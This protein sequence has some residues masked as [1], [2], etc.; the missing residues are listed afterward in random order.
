MRG[1]FSGD[2]HANNVISLVPSRPEFSGSGVGRNL[3]TWSTVG[4]TFNSFQSPYG[5]GHTLYVDG[6]GDYALHAVDARTAFGTGDFTVEAWVYPTQPPPG[7]GATYDAGVFGHFGTPP[8]FFFLTNN[9]Y[10]PAVWDGT[11]QRTGSISVQP[12]CWSH[13]SWSRRNGTLFMHVNGQL[14]YQAAYTSNFTSTSACYSGGHFGTNDRYYK[15]Y[16]AVRVTRGVGRY[17]GGGYVPPQYLQQTGVAIPSRRVSFAVEPT[18]TVTRRGPPIGDPHFNNVVLLLPFEHHLNDVS[19]YRRGYA[20]VGS[21]FQLATWG[22]M[23]RQQYVR[24]SAFLGGSDSLTYL[25]FSDSA[26]LEFGASDFCM[27]AWVRFGSPMEDSV[28]WGK[29]NAFDYGPYTL[30]F[31]AS[32]GKLRFASSATGTAWE[33]QMFSVTSLVAQRWYH[34]AITRRGSAWRMFIDGKLDVDATSSHSVQDTTHALRFGS[35]SD[36]VG[37]MY[38]YLSHVRFTKGVA[39]YTSNFT[40]PAL[41][42]PSRGSAPRA[43]SLTAGLRP[44]LRR[45]GHND[46]RGYSILE[47]PYVDSAD[48]MSRYRTAAAVASGSPTITAAGPL[49]FAK[50]LSLNGSSSYSYG[51]DSRWALGGRPF[52]IQGWV[53]LTSMPSVYATVMSTIDDATQTGWRLIIAPDGSVALSTYDS[54]NITIALAG[55]V[56]TNRWVH[57][58]V[59]WRNYVWKSFV[60][61]ARAREGTR[62]NTLDSGPQALRVGQTL[63]GAWGL[64][65]YLRGLRVDVDDTTLRYDA[66]RDV[67]LMRSRFLPHAGTL[68]STLEALTGTIG[69]TTAATVSDISAFVYA[70]NTIAGSMHPAVAGAV[71]DFTN[72]VISYGTIGALSGPAISALAAVLNTVGSVAA[73][74]SGTTA[75]FTGQ[76]YDILLGV[77]SQITLS[78]PA[79]ALALSELVSSLALSLPDSDLGGYPPIV[80]SDHILH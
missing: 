69:S 45:G 54:P 55:S 70:A 28:L 61:G 64:T 22:V 66:P 48:D 79:A 9:T 12:Y 6:A 50:C 15:G 38:G 30:D 76:V 40:P 21:G 60:D 57:L 49:P 65:G 35:R 29:R 51:V 10:R 39:R 68:A 18:P 25:T 20:T 47:L 67:L 17:D 80:I 75:E 37:G 4:D 59:A 16:L 63:G 24:T 2:L 42:P 78:S 13:I 73:Q 34:V 3:I 23:E 44:H 43:F 14:C 77:V 52:I 31:T 58:A 7:G 33:V 41:T 32:T 74:T 46:S 72:K 11:A 1:L 19:L 36:S 53:Y 27:E 56:S 26:S 71:S 8:M 62:I 5:R